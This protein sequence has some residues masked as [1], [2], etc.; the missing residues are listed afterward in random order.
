MHHL[1]SRRVLFVNANETV[2]PYRV[3]PLGLAFV[4]TTTERAGHYVRFLDLPQTASGHR[5]YRTL[6]RDWKPEYVA[7]GIRNLDNSDFHALE[8]YL[9]GPAGLIRE[10]RRVVPRVKVVVGG[11]AG[12]VEPDRV[13]DATGCDHLILGEG[14]ASLPELIARIEAGEFVPRI[15]GAD[16]RGTPFRVANTGNLPAPELHRWL[17]NFAL[18]LRGDAGYPVQTKRGCPLKCTYCT[19]GRVEGARYRFLNPQTI[20]DEL[21]GALER[22][23]RDFEFVDSTF[24]LPVPH[25]LEVLRTL[26]QRKLCANYIGTGLNPQQLPDELL[27]SMRALGFRSVILTAESA[28]DAMLASY[29]KNYRRDRLFAAAA[30]LQRHD[31]RALWVF[32]LGGPGETPETVGQTLSFIS[33]RVPPPNAVYITS[34]IRIYPGSPIGD[35][36]DLR[37]LDYESLRRRAEHPEVPF[38]YSSQTPPD[39]LE[40]RLKLF[41]HSHPHVML[42]CEAHA[43]LTQAALSVMQCLPVRKP[44]WQYIPALNA[45][46]RWLRWPKANKQP[47]APALL[48]ALSPSPQS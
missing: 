41:Q 5:R 14:E 44:Y 29:Q 21:K 13:A 20:A 6:L 16:N 19:Y 11:P 32:L 27:D 9:D 42:S 22:G 34:G 26:R 40:T 48:P 4:A 12:T 33:D 30:A 10:A 15:V 37:R 38:F 24:N 8:T 31:I 46:R 35:D 1:L 36:L 2:R 3:A 28:S 23:I 18:Y 7:L 17:R 25:A 45:T 43:W 39:W 47:S